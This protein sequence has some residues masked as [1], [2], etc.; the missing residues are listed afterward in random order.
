MEGK[1]IESPNLDTDFKEVEALRQ[2]VERLREQNEELKKALLSSL[3]ARI[4]SLL[5]LCGFARRE[6]LEEPSED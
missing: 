4:Y 1:K 2:E 3:D 5:G 6:D